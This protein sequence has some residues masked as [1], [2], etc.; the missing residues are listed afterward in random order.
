MPNFYNIN[1]GHNSL[2]DVNKKNGAAAPKVSFEKYIDP[3]GEFNTK[4]FKW[5]WW[6]VRN[7]IKVYRA[8]VIT[9][10]IFSVI[11][12]GYALIQV[13]D[14]LIFGLTQDKNLEIALTNSLNYKLLC[15]EDG[16]ELNI[17]SIFEKYIHIKNDDIKNDD[18][19]IQIINYL[20]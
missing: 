4:E 20:I 13:G 6:Y 19:K 12:Y 2:P 14:Y 17:I 16:L 9:L 18:I 7:K 3:T 11:T 8:A 1:N 5:S 15:K 10:I